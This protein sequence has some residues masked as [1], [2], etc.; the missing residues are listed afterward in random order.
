MNDTIKN[1]Y[2]A[3]EKLRKLRKSPAY[4]LLADM[5]DAHADQLTAQEI[6]DQPLQID[7]FLLKIAQTALNLRKD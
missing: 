7:D 1:L 4:L 6:L 3:A 2:R 5:L